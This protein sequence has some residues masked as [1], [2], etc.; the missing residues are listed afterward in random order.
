MMTAISSRIKPPI[1]AGIN[2]AHALANG[3]VGCWLLNEGAGRVVRDLSRP[4]HD[5]GFSGGPGWQPGAFGPAVEFDGNDSWISMG[6]CLNLGTDDVTLLTLVQYSAA[7]QPEQWAGEH[8]AAIAGKGYLCP[9]SGYGLS[10]GVGNRI[11]WQVR[12]QST[13]FSIASNSALNDGQWHVAIAL[14]DRDSSTG[15]RLHIDGVPQSA[16]ADPTPIAG[17]DLSDSTAFAVGSRQDTGQAWAWDF[18]GR[19]A[20]V[21]V[22]KRVLTGSEIVQLQREPFA[23]FARRPTTACFAPFAGPVVNVTGSAHGVS[24]AS[25]TLRVVRGLSGRSTAGATATATLRKAGSPTLPAAMPW[26]REVL[27]NGLTPAACRLGTVLTHGWFW[28]RRNGGT[29]LYRGP[30]LQQVD[31]GRILCVADPLSGEIV[32]P[33]HLSPP[34]GS[35]DCYVVRRFN[36]CGYQERTSAAAVTVR[37]GMEGESVLIAPNTVFGLA[38]E[39]IDG[40]RLRLR[41]LYYPLDQDASPREFRIYGDGGAGRMDLENPLATIPYG[42]CGFYQWQTGPLADGRYTFVIYPCDVNHTEVLCPGSIT[43]HVA[44]LSPDAATIL[45]AEAV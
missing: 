33:A 18:L 5:G 11:C 36:G 26:L 9:S 12:N 19:V 41:W 10:I 3:L 37:M 15:V 17:I 40:R 23:L 8:I 38:G 45:G 25:A 29:A 35:A 1:A 21:C 22:W 32:L 20:A 14:C 42:G 13:M 6:N 34:A 27:F 43:C 2:P 24:S 4:R 44:G 16:T 39:Q 7:D 30:G 28:V 31:F